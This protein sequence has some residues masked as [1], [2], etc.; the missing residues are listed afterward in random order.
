MSK[1]VR[2]TGGAY[3]IVVDNGN[4]ILLDTSDGNGLVTVNG[5]LLVTGTTTTVQSTVLTVTDNII[6]IN[7]GEQGNGVSQN[8]NS[9]GINIQ[10]G[11]YSDARLLFKENE[12]HYDPS[13][14]LTTFGTWVFEEADGSLLGIKTNSI[15]TGTNQDLNLIGNG[16]GVITVKNTNNYEQQVINYA[17]LPYTSKG[18]DIVPNNKAMVD[19]VQ[20]Y[21]ANTT[22]DRIRSGNSPLWT[23]VQVTDIGVVSL[24]NKIDFLVHGV[25]KAYINS[26][27]LNVNSVNVSSNT[28][29]TTAGNLTITASTNNVDVDAYVN[30]E[31]Q[32]TDPALR[33]G[34]KK[35]YAKAGEGNGGTGIYYINE[36]GTTDE[37]ISKT[38]SLLYSLIL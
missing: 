9:A 4:D 24:T 34:Y 2:V 13:T 27:G 30:L 31:N 17:T 19:Y 16:T 32:A 8:G 15:K 7:A 28:I 6:E 25:Q 3:K 10:R 23:Q 12:S 35:I 37:L 33:A 5:D 26:T 18:D 29:T 36:G 21:V 11:G 20:S 22:T 1:I 38:K 14:A